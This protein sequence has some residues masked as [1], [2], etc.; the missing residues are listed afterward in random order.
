[1]IIHIDDTGIKST[2]RGKQMVATVLTQSA[3]L[4]I[5]GKSLIS[6][7]P[8]LH[9]YTTE[10]G[11]KGITNT[12][13]L[14]AT[15]FAD[16]NDATEVRLLQEPLAAVL[17][18]RFCKLVKQRQSES[19]KVRR[20]VS[21]LGG[22]RAVSTDLARDFVSSLYSVTFDGVGT[23]DFGSPFITSFC[24]HSGDQSYEKENG[25]LSQWRGYGRDG[26]YCIVFGTHEL[27]QLLGVEF[28]VNYYVHMNMDAAR[29]ALDGVSVESLFPELLERCDLFMSELL[30]GNRQ[31]AAE[32]GFAPFVT[33]A[34][35]L[36][37]QGFRE[38]REIRIVSMPGTK[39]VQ[40]QVCKEHPEYVAKP[41]KQ[42]RKVTS[43][44]G[45][46]RHIVLF[47]GLEAKLPIKRVIVGPSRRQDDNFKFAHTLLD[48]GTNIVRSATPFVG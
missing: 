29:Y 45:E 44:F 41:V 15:H 6:D 13:C 17:G 46:R 39:E 26:G 18:S 42:V 9:H 24:T 40:D 16:L 5:V 36:K 10:A 37:H 32:D 2:V 20:A 38:E 3:P 21:D 12:N 31:P 27:S 14:W 22:L 28:D 7:H 23:F 47:E 35:L 34:T 25:L 1:M 30:K 4:T 11:L 8:E 43:N 33:G 19:L 48:P